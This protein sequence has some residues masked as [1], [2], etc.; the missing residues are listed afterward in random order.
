MCKWFFDT[1]KMSCFSG[2]VLS[3]FVYSRERLVLRCETDLDCD[4]ALNN[5]REMNNHRNS[6]IRG[7]MR[8]QRDISVIRLSTLDSRLSTLD[9]RLSTNLL[10]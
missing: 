9:S 2:L 5:E 7:R 3:L 6:R 8:T 10:N 1:D 4:T